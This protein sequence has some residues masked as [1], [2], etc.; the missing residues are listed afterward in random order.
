VRLSQLANQ[1]KVLAQELAILRSD[2]ARGD[3]H[4]TNQPAAGR[5]PE[6]EPS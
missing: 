2:L 1:M 5:L 4:A 6:V 3:L